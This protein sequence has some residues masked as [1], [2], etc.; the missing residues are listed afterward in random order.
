MPISL[1]PFGTSTAEFDNTDSFST[2]GSELLLTLKWNNQFSTR[3]GYTYVN[4]DSK[5]RGRSLDAGRGAPPLDPDSALLERPKHQVTLLANYESS[6]GFSGYVQGSYQSEF[7]DTKALSGDPNEFDTNEVIKV[8]G[9]FLFNGKIA[10]EVWKGVKP[11][12]MVENIFDSNYEAIRGYP[13]PGRRF[14][15]GVNA[16]FDSLKIFG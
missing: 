10:Y 13:R 14:F 8:Q 11:F 3:L 5:G 1:Q 7:V 16:K 6:L 12:V 2:I 4:T 9:R 15:F